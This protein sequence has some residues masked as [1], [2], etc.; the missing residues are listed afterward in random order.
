MMM[1]LLTTKLYIPALRPMLVLRPRLIEQLNKGINRKLTLISA[2]AG[3]GKTTLVCEWIADY[4]RPVAWLSLDENDNEPTRFLTYIIATLQ[5]IKPDI[6]DNLLGVLQSP[7]A[8]PIE[9]ILTSLLN[10]MTTI[11]DNFILVLDDYHLVESPSIDKVLSFLLK[12]LPPQIHLVIITRE[13]PN[14]PLARL[15]AQ[16]QLTELRVA[17]L[18]FTPDEVAEFLN[19]VMSLNLAPEDVEALETRTE[20]WIVGLQLAAISMQGH[21]DTISFIKSFAGSHHFVLDYLLEEVLNQQSEDIQAF[22]LHTSILNRLCGSLCDAMLVDSGDSGQATLEYLER[23]NLF[24][25]PLDNERRWYRYHHLFRDLLRQR[26]DQTSI[27]VTEL[28]HRASQ[29]YEDN[30]FAIEAFQ[31]AIAGHDIDR[32]ELLLEGDDIPLLFHGQVAPILAWLNSLPT[33]VLDARPALWI[34]SAHA[35]AYLGEATGIEQKLK[36]AETILGDDS[37]DFRNRNRIGHIAT[38]R[39]MLGVPHNQIDVI[40]HQSQRA[41]DYLHPD[42][43][44][45]RTSAMWTLGYAYQVQGNRPAAIQTFSE[46]ISTSNAS[47]N[48][49]NLLAATSCLGNVQESEN[50]LDLA[51]E[52]YQQVIDLVGDPPLPYACESFL[53]LARIAYERNDLHTAEQYAQ[54]SVD[55]AQ[56]IE[57]V[58][59]PALGCMTLARIK[60]IQGDVAGALN[61]L[62]TAEQIIRQQNFEHQFANLTEMQVWVA[63]H[64]G[65]LNRASHLVNQYDIPISQARVYLAQDNPSSAL[66]VL[67]PYRKQMDAKGW[68]DE[69]LRA[70]LLEIIVLDRLN[71]REDALQLL[72]DALLQ[73]QSAGL[74]RSFLDE[75]EAMLE[76]LSVAQTQDMM[77]DYVGTLLATQSQ[78]GVKVT[79]DQPLIEPLSDRELEILHL[80]AEGLSNRE[81]SERLFLALDTIKGHNRRIFG[82]L[83]VKRRTEA[84][85][86][87]REL[88]LI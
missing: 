81:I 19:Q 74:I 52:S 10:E 21:Q 48:F 86:I 35:S 30:G 39:A 79:A 49:M 69:Q 8:P 87:A 46:A 43:L 80:I 78:S 32:A 34:W 66:T 44:H 16:G 51:T 73:A 2:P 28:H 65:D 53:G 37:S 7:Q 83:H 17:D 24:L 62:A 85:A 67:Q 27:D 20:G 26:L 63:L 60:F 55:L 25:I 36:I 42:N 3:F 57:N 40:F 56:Q 88:G 77:S 23:A 47:G 76:L 18:R 68:Q 15:R 82:K 45:L 54:Q 11:P 4:G 6:G 72:S 58:D 41:L 29:W 50:M 13:D 9:T 61:L 71:R 22:L 59:T 5:T 12:N 84:V 33:T 70:M 64:Q 38:I 1:P 75:G 31:H 14:L